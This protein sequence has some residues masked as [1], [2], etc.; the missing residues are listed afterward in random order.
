MSPCLSLLPSGFLAHLL[1]LQHPSKSTRYPLLLPS[2]HP[3]LANHRRTPPQWYCKPCIT[4]SL[5]TPTPLLIT[6]KPPPRKSARPSKTIDYANLDNHLPSD[7]SRWLRVLDTRETVSNAFRKMKGSELTDEWI[8]G[9]GTGSFEEPFLVEEPEGLGMLMPKRDMGI[10]EI[11]R[12][13]GMFAMSFKL[14]TEQALTEVATSEGP[15][16]PIEVIGSSLSLSRLLSSLADS[17][18]SPLSLPPPRLALNSL[19]SP[20]PRPLLSLTPSSLRTDVASQSSLSS[21]TLQQWAD[22][23]T[24][25]NRDKVRNVIS[26]E[27]SES[28]LGRRV[29]APEIVR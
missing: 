7:A 5:S 6:H 9:E 28:P 8:W 19:S 22:Y 1:H 24:D 26:L 14:T 16:T 13:V 23:Y 2:V 21:W 25:P 3:T 10:Q 15:K 20:S 12:V 4:L 11:A 27:V 17:H 29:V 18:L